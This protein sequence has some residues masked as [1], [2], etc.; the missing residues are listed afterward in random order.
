MHGSAE[1]VKAL[2]MMAHATIEMVGD[3]PWVWRAGAVRDK[4]GHEGQNAVTI[5]TPTAADSLEHRFFAFLHT[6]YPRESIAILAAFAASGVGY[7]AAL[8]G[9]PLSLEAAVVAITVMALL[10]FQLAVADAIR[11]QAHADGVWRE[12]LGRASLLALAAGAAAIQATLTLALHPP[13]MGP[14]TLAW[15]VIACASQDFFIA[16]LRRRPALSVGLHLIGLGCAGYYVA[17]AELFRQSGEA[18]PGLLAFMAL[19]ISSGLAMELARK[20]QAPLDERAGVATYSKAWGPRVAGMAVSAAVLAALV[21]AAAA[22]LG[23]GGFPGLLLPTIG[24]SAAAYLAAVAF[25]LRPERAMGDWMRGLTSVFVAIAFVT[26]G[27]LPGLAR[28]LGWA[29]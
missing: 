25:A 21:A 11:D 12:P 28:L 13:L 20:T 8:L 10:S 6:R 27:I 19:T 4:Q 2:R 23:L 29:G 26:V 24:V 1:K 3:R 15:L 5:S 18:H 16:D 7:G 9:R 22:Y 17:G 14:L